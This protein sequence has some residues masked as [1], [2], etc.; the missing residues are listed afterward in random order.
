MQPDVYCR[1]LGLQVPVAVS[2]KTGQTADVFHAICSIAMKPS[3]P[4]NQSKHEEHTLLFNLKT[5]CH[6]WRRRPSNNRCRKNTD[7]FYSYRYCG[8]MCCWIGN[9]G[10]DI[11][12]ARRAWTTVMDSTV[13]DVVIGREEVEHLDIFD[14]YLFCEAV[15]IEVNFTI[16]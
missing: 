13:G 9:A 15:Y 5:S 1:R 10:A 4:F 16:T 7:V 2:V 8:R 11:A 6:P 14:N 12:E 3:V